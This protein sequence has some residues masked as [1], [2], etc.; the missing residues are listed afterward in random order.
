[1]PRRSRQGARS[2]RL[3]IAEPYDFRAL[4]GF[5]SRRA[6]PGVEQVDEDSYARHFALDGGPGRLRVTLAGG[7]KALALALEG[8]AAAHVGA[9]RACVQRMFDVGADMAAI[10][11]QLSFDA[12]LRRCIARYPGQ[13]L[14]GGWD[15]FEIAVRAVLG[16]QISV[17]AA[18]TLAQRLVERHGERLQTRAGEEIRMFPSPLVL[19]DAD[20]TRIGLPRARAA[21]LNAI[22]RAVCDGR[23][24]F[25]QEQPLDEFVA[26]W[27]ELPG[28]GEWTA[29]YIALRGLS[30]PDAFPAGDLVLRKAVSGDGTPVPVRELHAMAESWRPWRAYAVL[31]LWRSMSQTQPSARKRA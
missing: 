19:A 4:T 22:A 13:R 26:S 28:V 25:A 29:H 7:G 11:A 23:V 30:H 20:L 31:H 12:R 21:A 16:Q 24:G 10:H 8:V 5:F 2:L 1:V 18:R 3:A 14:P 6:I 9:V 17:A 27:T 15:G